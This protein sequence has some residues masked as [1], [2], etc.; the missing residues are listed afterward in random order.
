LIVRLVLDNIKTSQIKCGCPR[1][2]ICGFFV[3]VLYDYKIVYL[4]R[5]TSQNAIASNVNMRG[6]YTLAESDSRHQFSTGD[7]L[8]SK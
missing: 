8:N 5:V 1:S 7:F 2:T 3:F 4:C 6:G